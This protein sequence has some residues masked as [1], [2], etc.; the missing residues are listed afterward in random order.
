MHSRSRALALIL[1]SLALNPPNGSR[2]RSFSAA[3]LRGGAGGGFLLVVRRFFPL[4][5]SVFCLLSLSLPVRADVVSA[6]KGL[7][8]PDSVTFLGAEQAASNLVRSV[9]VVQV[10]AM[11]PTTGGPWAAASL[12][13]GP[14]RRRPRSLGSRAVTSWSRSP[15]S[16]SRCTRESIPRPASIGLNA[17]C[18]TWTRRMILP[19]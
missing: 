19:C 3:P 15:N 8:N 17:A 10:P 6:P 1:P 4:L 5:S 14:G 16:T 9:F 13:V 12:S 2:F 18:C 7:P 11:V